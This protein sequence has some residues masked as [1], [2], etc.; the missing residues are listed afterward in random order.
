[1]IKYEKDWRYG[2]QTVVVNN[3]NIDQE[4][5]NFINAPKST[6]PAT[7]GNQEPTFLIEQFVTGVREY[8]W[9]ALCNQTGWQYLGTSRDYKKRFENDQGYNTASMGS[10]SPVPDVNA[11]IND[12]ADAI[13]KFLIK[14]G[15][16]YVGILYLG[17]MIDTNGVPV[18]LEINTRPGSPEIESILPTINSNLLD[19]FYTTATNQTIPKVEFNDRS[20]VS[21]RIVNKTYNETIDQSKEKFVMPK[22]WPL[23][24]N[25]ML[26][27]GARSKLLHSLLTIDGTSVDQAADQIYKFLNNKSMGDYTYRTDIGYFK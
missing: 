2:L 19:L 16:P 5:H 11:R 26:S 23:T 1:M 24:G 14:R 15:T 6:Y 22:L 10:Y 9:H 13:V 12:Y 21:L 7:N 4:F 27:L 18:V 17:I 20:A 8:S 25:M 3:E